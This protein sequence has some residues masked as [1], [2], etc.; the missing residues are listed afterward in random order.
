MA[1]KKKTGPAVKV[2]VKSAPRS[3]ELGA[4]A[5]WLGAAAGV[6]FLLSYLAVPWISVSASGMAGVSLISAAVQSGNHVVAG[7][8]LFALVPALLAAGAPFVPAHRPGVREWMATL[9]AIAAFV[10]FL[11]LVI[12]SSSTRNLLALGSGR[13]VFMDE[14]Y[15]VYITLAG[16]LT[17][18]V[19]YLVLR[20]VAAE[21]DSGEAYWYAAFLVAALAI[22]YFNYAIL[23]DSLI[24]PPDF[25][26]ERMGM[27][28]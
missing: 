8:L 2:Q 22:L 21:Q 10:E 26:R 7:A 24:P 19:G 27:L 14:I 17:G 20:D 25:I 5:L 13:Q 6:L 18:A 12:L 11:V 4:V 16:V 15:L 9:T 23:P 1:K 28:G 3:A